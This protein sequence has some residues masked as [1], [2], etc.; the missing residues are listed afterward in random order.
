M[1]I[2]FAV[3][4]GKGHAQNIAHNAPYPDSMSC[5]PWATCNDKTMLR[6]FYVWYADLGQ[7]SKRGQC[8]INHW[9]A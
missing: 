8:D 2:K 6:T 7:R 5:G 4:G 9:N 3:S 1:V